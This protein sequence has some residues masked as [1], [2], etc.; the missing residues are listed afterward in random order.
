MILIR[1]P[2]HASLASS[3]ALISIFLGSRKDELELVEELTASQRAGCTDDYQIAHLRLVLSW[4]PGICSTKINCNGYSE[5]FT[6]HGFWPTFKNTKEYVHCC[7]R[8]R[9]NYATIRPFEKNLHNW[10]PALNGL[11][12]EEFWFYQ[13]DKHGRCMSKI[14]KV[15]TVF[16]YFY[17][18]LLNFQKYQIKNALIEDG[19]TPDDEDTYLGRDIV[20]SLQDTYGVKVELNCARL[21]DNPEMVILTEVTICFN[22]EL[23]PIDCPYSKA[24]CLG[25]ILLPSEAI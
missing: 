9:Y 10:W 21:D 25:T 2:G 23:K 1:S 24:R 12:N 20:E 4:G 8:E 22:E 17:F 13:W 5:D 18:I 6:I 14:G 16:N 19:F 11:K 15:N 3:L 7:T